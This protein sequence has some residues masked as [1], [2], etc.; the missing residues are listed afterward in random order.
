[1]KFFKKKTKKPKLHISK[2]RT[3]KRKA[4]EQIAQHYD[5]E[6][7]VLTS[8]KKQNSFTSKELENL[9]LNDGVLTYEP[10]CVRKRTNW[11]HIEPFYTFDHPKFSPEEFLKVFPSYSPKLVALIDKINELDRADMREHGHLFKHFIFSDLKTNPFGAKMLASAMISL[12]YQLGYHAERKDPDAKRLYHRIQMKDEN[13]LVRDSKGNNFY[14]LASNSVYDQSISVMTKKQILQSFNRRPENI[15]GDIARFIIMDS[16]FKEGI[17]LFDIKY[18][19]MFEPS[20]VASYQTQT[21]GRGTRTCGQKGLEFHPTRGWPLY[22]FIYDISVP[23][24]LQPTFLNAG[25]GIDLFLKSKNIDLK[26]LYFANQL[27]ELSIFGAVDYEL[28]RGIHQFRISENME[29]GAPKLKIRKDIPPL[30]ID[31]Q[32]TETGF[33]NVREWIREHY[34]QFSWKNM[35]MENLCVESAANADT[36]DDRNKKGIIEYTPSQQFLRHYFT[37]ISPLKGMLLW[38]SVGTG[39]TCA[40]IATATGHFEREGYTILWV[41]RT[42][43]KNDIWKNM[44]DQVC[45]EQI[46]YRLDTDTD[47]TVPSQQDKR[48]RLLSKSWRIRP[49]SYKQFSNLVSKRNAFY[50]TLVKINGE[51]DPLRKTLIIIDEAHKLYGGDDLSSIEKPDMEAFHQ[52]IQQSY[53]VSGRESVRLLLMSATPITK[54]PFEIIKLLNLCKLSEY[55]LPTTYESFAES[56]LDADT[57]AFTEMGRMRYLDAISGHISYLNR[58]RDA[59]QFAQPFISQI[60][61]PITPDLTQIK[62]FDKKW[63]REYMN[64]NISLLEKQI[65]TKNKELE[66]EYGDIIPERFHYLTHDLCSNVEN[67]SQEKCNK[68]AKRN[69]KLLVQELKRDTAHFENEINRLKELVSKEKEERRAEINKITENREQFESEYDE[70]KK[71]P[72]SVIKQDCAVRIDSLSELAKNIHKHPQIAEYDRRIAN[73]QEEMENWKEG[74][75]ERIKI[76]RARIQYLRKILKQDLSDLE[77]QVI[78]STIRSTIRDERRNYTENQNK[79]EK[80]IKDSIANQEKQRKKI[81]MRIR[82]TAKKMLHNKKIEE[83]KQETEEKRLRKTLMRQGKYREEL[84]EGKVKEVVDKYS[85]HIQTEFTNLMKSIQDKEAKKEA[86]KKE[87]EAKKEADK[88]EKEAKKEADKKEK[89]AKKEADK[90]EKEAKKEADKKEKEAKKEAVRTRKIIEKEEKRKQREHNRTQKK[91]S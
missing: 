49:M 69:I 21:I 11:S 82:R 31:R 41:T 29:G 63:V 34:G 5:I 33:E 28:N 87:K 38:W 3:A 20:T 35:K 8:N 39:K 60:H 44:F 13:R 22:V 80:R 55:S 91:K 32:R 27:E 66:K 61:V 24:V 89:E 30:I 72:F 76:Y 90:K 52:S 10:T 46:R 42:T 17:D 59:R 47:Y 62:Q 71:T 45:N 9:L 73:Y 86:D 53:A 68:I 88:K 75:K 26:Q 77:R 74:M 56:F 19:H 25:N 18:I 40:A 81:F 36:N 12:E 85:Q 50:K 23:E 54:S 6:E 1:M 4:I 16:G 48:M 70:Y 7:Q 79:E 57:G 51:A 78:R 84:S 65:D 37:P 2:N 58:E 43:L 67:K 14:L 83:R 64:S 15:H